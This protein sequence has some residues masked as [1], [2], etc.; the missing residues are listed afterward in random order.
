MKNDIS[1]KLAKLTPEQRAL[2]EKKL[3]EKSAKRKNNNS[4]SVRENLSEY[5]MSSAQKRLWF[6]DQ[7]NK[8]SAFY[9]IHSALKLTGKL[10]IKV[11]E[12]SIKKVLERHQVLNVVFR[13]EDN[14]PVQKLKAYDFS[15]EIKNVETLNEFD[16][17]KLINDEATKPFNLSEG[18]LF[19]AKLLTINDNNN[20][21][22][23]T[24][25]HI[26]A[27]GWSV[28]ILIKE[29][30]Q[31]YDSLLKNNKD[32]LAPL[33][34]QYFDYAN[35]SESNFSTKNEE[36]H[37][38]FWKEALSGM[39]QILNLPLDKPR[40]SVQTF[41]GDRVS[42]KVPKELANKIKIIGKESAVTPFLTYLSVFEILL[43][44]YSLQEDFGIGT[45]IS[46]RQKKETRD[47]IGFF[48]NTLVMRAQLNPNLNFRT[49]LKQVKEF[50]IN[51]FEYQSLQFDKLVDNIL[52][53]R[54]TSSSPLFQVM[55][56]YQESPLKNIK[57][58]DI[59]FEI[60]NPEMKITKFEL[61][62]IL[63]ESPA[64]VTGVFEFNTDLYNRK[65][66]KRFADSYLELLKSISVS[67]EKPIDKLSI[68]NKT[69][70]ER[71]IKKMNTVVSS[72]PKKYCLHQLFEQQ[73]KIFP[74]NVAIEFNNIGLS[75]LELNKKSNKLARYL[76]NKG[77][78]KGELI[79]VHLERNN[80][81]IISI[82]AI[83]KA[84]GAYLPMDPMYPK[85]RLNFMLSD[86]K[87]K[88]LITEKKYDGG[89]LQDTLETIIVDED[90]SAIEKESSDN[91]VL[92]ITPDQTAYVIY[93]SGSTGKP[94][95]T[96]ISHYNVVRLF[97]SS[98]TIF[99]FNSNDVW[100]LFHS[101]SF[102][103]SVWE[104]WG[105]L[106]YGGKLIIVPSEITKSPSEFYNLLVQKNVTVLNQTPVAF[107]QLSNI[108]E[109]RKA[110]ELVSSLKYIIFGGEA[111]DFNQLKPWI[112]NHGYKSPTLIN[113]YGITETTV[114]V[115]YKVITE[116]DIINSNNHSI[117]NP[118]PDLQL[119]I[120]DNNLTPQQIGVPGEICVSGAGLA[121]GYLF[122]DTLTKQKFIDNPFCKNSKLY[123]SGDLGRF[124]DNG[125]VEYLGRIDKQ[126]KLR[127]FRI[128]L[129]E[130]EK[131][132]SQLPEIKKSVVLLHGET[133]INKKLV[134]FYIKN[135][136]SFIQE[137][138]I[139]KDISS[140]LPDYMIPSQFIEI[141]E[142]PI[143]NNGKLDRKYLLNKI[144][145]A[146]RITQSNYIPPRNKLEKYLKEH[147]ENILEIEKIGI[148]DDFF[149]VG[150]NSI[151]AAILANN[152]QND[153]NEI[154][155]VGTIFFTPT[156]YEIA[157]HLNSYF[158]IKVKEIFGEDF[159]EY[160][161]E[162][163][164]VDYANFKPIDNSHIKLFNSFIPKLTPRNKAHITKKNK[165]AIFILSP[166]RSGSTLFRI[167]MAGNSQIFAPPE[168]ELMS[169]STMQERNQAFKN[170][171][172]SLKDGTVKAIMELKSV[173][174][175]EAVEFIKQ[176]ED[177]DLTIQQ[178]YGILQ[179]LIG[180]KILVDKTPV[181]SL[182][183]EILNRIEEDFDEPLFIHLIRHPYASIYS[184]IE[185]K[186]SSFVFRQELPFDIR[187]IA[188]LVW[189]TSH[190]NII[191][192]LKTIPNK[193]QL[194]LKFEDIVLNPET[195]MKAVSDFIG[196]EYDEKMIMPYN[197]ERMTTGVNMLVPMV[198]DL[199]F[200][201]HKSINPEVLDKWKEK[202]KFDFLSAPSKSLAENFN[203]ET[204]F[205]SN[206]SLVEP[207][208][209][210]SK[211]ELYL[212]K[213]WE[214][215][216]KVSNISVHDDFFDLG[217]NSLLA[218]VFTNRLQKD[219]KVEVQ[220][221]SI[222]LAP[223]ISE[224]SHYAKEYYPEIISNKFG[225][226]VKTVTKDY[227]INS[228]KK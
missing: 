187:E 157:K 200:Y 57:L 211:L 97:Q 151:Q 33:K 45:L 154:F 168:L 40:P 86:S 35:W 177:S 14:Q 179:N 90:N 66:I 124:I 126:I 205:Y 128:E 113:M 226:D 37:I 163:S 82:L 180:D 174:E 87:V 164:N 4:I 109:S 189:Y 61:L 70:E 36:K 127:G 111:L 190:N 121:K 204:K 89:Y 158:N 38:A 60:I 202:H 9:N 193:R 159:S 32:I 218:A 207:T 198:G 117:G 73:A 134:A 214:D 53:E 227:N 216:L 185:S 125:E 210:L 100:T 56:D 63:E 120:L 150:G 55:F 30:T 162:K 153:F 222:F 144:K 148:H 47:L 206:Y 93:T 41:N 208:S 219:F 194:Q 69:E 172:N 118:L 52:E 197:S 23:I 17:Q 92:D 116:N 184:F 171:F 44:R 223:T 64:G 173:S 58:E 143:T 50:A 83:L 220:V 31:L 225:E 201:M 28:G 48:V 94:K 146:K 155:H 191:D 182:N 96:I 133:E 1:K 68:L 78:K 130:I 188:E 137:N 75:Y 15:L 46:D 110:E 39:P 108:E 115:T 138:K 131:V 2:L 6:L 209:K 212:I 217:G 3:R 62:L 199:K 140:K 102:D 20:I 105:A 29:V 80:N 13:V 85:D 88:I 221:Q 67:P 25:H 147:W 215:I 170:E 81:L 12:Q 178:F 123:R 224:F 103:F 213:L 24:L 192:F 71:L 5:P 167:M 228:S 169:F 106:I 142:I 98:K 10:N 119:Y 34:I 122:R 95:G 91:V 11:L 112:K 27:D 176:F 165:K 74:E 135:D 161:L 22:L 152:L 166:P 51:A 84:G 42:F 8:G 195:N 203:Y 104:I 183:K 21:L 160:Y 7:L 156:I 181:Y 196:I 186:M 54:N 76:I 141:S 149:K 65:T 99:D 16:I 101:Y 114:H 19:I 145:N 72:Y 139:K 43:Y 18:P 107:F 129:G 79:A 132:L 26:V 175:N 59:S 136:N 77:V 49:L